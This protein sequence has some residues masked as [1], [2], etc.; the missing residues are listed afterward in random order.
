M[1]IVCRKQGFRNSMFATQNYLILEAV[2]SKLF[3]ILVLHV[4]K[5]L[6]NAGLWSVYYNAH[7]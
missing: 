2:D 5:R 1:K 6:A 4:F 3:R 7:S